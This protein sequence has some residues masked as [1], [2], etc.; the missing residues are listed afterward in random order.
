MTKEE[1]KE[2][3]KECPWEISLYNDEDEEIQLAIVEENPFSIRYIQNP[4]EKVQIAAV[5]DMLSSFVYIMRP[6]QAVVDMVQKSW[7]SDKYV[8]P[9]NI[10]PNSKFAFYE[11]VYTEMSQIMT[12]FSCYINKGVKF[13]QYK[14]LRSAMNYLSKL[15][16]WCFENG[17]RACYI[18]I[19]KVDIDNIHEDIEELLTERHD[20]FGK[21]YTEFVHGAEIE[22]NYL[23]SMACGVEFCP[24]GHADYLVFEYDNE[25]YIIT[26]LCYE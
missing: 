7:N 10:T 5:S 4:T 12:H 1:I 16:N 21:N 24:D 19:R 9:K 13:F 8:I 3:V 11:P 20:K 2:V 14:T 17:S 22:S 15:D 6:C 26:I 23:L 18:D 25:Y